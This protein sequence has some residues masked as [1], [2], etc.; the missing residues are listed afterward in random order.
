MGLEGAGTPAK[1]LCVSFALFTP[2]DEFDATNS[3]YVPQIGVRARAEGGR[4]P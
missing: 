2:A 1:G 4:G 3:F